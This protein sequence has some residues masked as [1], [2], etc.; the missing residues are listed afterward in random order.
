MK[1]FILSFVVLIILLANGRRA[2][3][4][5]A[6]ETNTIV[7]FIKV[8]YTTKEEKLIFTYA[9]SDFKKAIVIWHHWWFPDGQF[10]VRGVLVEDQNIKFNKF[11][12][13]NTQNHFKT[14]LNNDI[15]QQSAR[16]IENI[17]YVPLG[18]YKTK[19]EAYRIAH[20][21]SNNVVFND[22][23]EQEKKEEKERLKKQRSKHY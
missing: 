16:L 8:D 22:L 4:N 21:L 3:T 5:D 7:Q 13:T 11:I 2:F 1:R 14:L 10:E 20:K 17:D 19:E 12:S 9:P 23:R 15:A 18:F 6:N